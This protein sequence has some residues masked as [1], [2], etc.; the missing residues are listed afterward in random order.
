MI[1]AVDAS[2]VLPTQEFGLIGVHDIGIERE[3]ISRVY[4]ATADVG[5]FEVKRG[6]RLR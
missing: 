6:L 3:Y 1:R 4:A 2:P 5:L